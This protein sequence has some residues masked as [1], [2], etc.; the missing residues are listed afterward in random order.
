MMEIKDL[1]AD[2]A[3]MLNQNKYSED[4]DKLKDILD[5]LISI[6]DEKKG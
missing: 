5:Y 3:Y 2:V 4:F 6:R 1:I